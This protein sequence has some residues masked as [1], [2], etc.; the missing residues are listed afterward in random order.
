MTSDKIN[1]TDLRKKLINRVYWL[2]A[3]TVTMFAIIIALIVMQQLSSYSL[4][5]KLS[6]YHNTTISH[7]HE[8]L[9]AIAT[10]RL[11]LHKGNYYK[12]K[13]ITTISEDFNVHLTSVVNDLTDIA[14]EN[15]EA[16]ISVQQQYNDPDFSELI[17][18]VLRSQEFASAT[19]SQKV[20]SSR[21]KNL[22]ISLDALLVPTQ[23]LNKL[24]KVASDEVLQAITNLR[25]NVNIAFI[26][27]FIPF[28]MVSIWVISVFLKKIKSI[29][30]NYEN[31][32]NA[33]EDSREQNYL[34]LQSTGEGIFGVDLDGICTFANPACLAL[35][36][37][38]SA[39]QLLGKRMH[40]LLQPHYQGGEN[41][42][43]KDSNI[44][45]SM[46]ENKQFVCDNEVF[47]H[48]DGSSFFVEYTT[49]P[50]DYQDKVH[51]SVVVFSN[52]N[53]RKNIE[54]DLEV[55]R[56]DLE[57]LVTERTYELV[58]AKEVAENADQLKTEFIGRMSHELRTPMNAILGFGQLLEGEDL[59]VEQSVNLHE[60]MQAGHHLLSL[61][62]DVL[63]LSIIENGHI[64][65][66]FSDVNISNTISD[67]ISLLQ[68]LSTST[69]IKVNTQLGLCK[70]IHVW[71]DHTRIKEVLINLISNAIKYNSGTADVTISCEVLPSQLLRINVI[72]NGPG[73]SIDDQVKLFEPFNRL[74]AEYSDIEGTGIGLSI[75][76]RLIDMMKG[77]IG[78]TSNPETGS[79]FW[80][81][82]AISESPAQTSSS[83]DTF[84]EQTFQPLNSPFSVLY[85]E[86]NAA[87][88]RLV[89]TALLQRKQVKFQSAITAEEGLTHA[90]HNRPDLILLDIGL[91]GMDGFE[92]MSRLKASPETSEIPVIAISAAAMPSDID[93]GLSAGFRQYLTKPI[94]ITDLINA[95]DELLKLAPT[96]KE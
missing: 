81:E 41:I 85:I 17:A 31:T 83:S 34:L 1:I 64:E 6:N 9:D 57:S 42:S 26:S 80:V 36:G 67:C 3:Y 40:S 76:K 78:V 28:I 87:N 82:L 49:T 90:R 59:T 84:G 32:L 8:I 93:R 48:A 58:R 94:Q 43:E 13:L 47:I 35:L 96:E 74:G 16:I 4:E 77:T 66:H 46:H 5:S 51:G 33:L 29:T 95:V 86:D 15:I 24:H 38:Q 62:N 18:S 2:V 7:T 55:Q 73:I 30:Y 70:D 79:T 39:D 72:D 52:I 89:E 75:C 23:Q 12:D 27:I 91:P 22:E 10:T 14:E 56:K 19:L 44:Y 71:A 53:K 50:I 21:L 92:A 68:P 45:Q 11:E 88:I 20:S 60:I 69:G 25:H 37:Y 61:I 63:D 54:N 65:L